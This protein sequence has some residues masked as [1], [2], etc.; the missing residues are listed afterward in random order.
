[1]GGYLHRV[2]ST[3]GGGCFFKVCIF[4]LDFC[5]PQVKVVFFPDGGSSSVTLH[6]QINI[7][8]IPTIDSFPKPLFRVFKLYYCHHIIQFYLILVAEIINNYFC[9]HSKV[10]FV[11]MRPLVLE[12]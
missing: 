4:F 9:A 6:Q 3:T 2:R 7:V 12:M 10:N 5:L 1:M 11:H 8:I